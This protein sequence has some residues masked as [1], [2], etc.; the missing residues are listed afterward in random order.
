MAEAP[1]VFLV[2][3]DHAVRDSLRWLVETINLDVETY[4]SAKSF[5]DACDPD[6]PGCLVLDVRMPGMSGLELQ[7]TLIGRGITLPIIVITGYGDVPSAVRAMRQGAVDFLEKPFDDQ[8]LLELIQHCVQRDA[9]NRQAEATRR[10][11]RKNLAKL[12]PREREVLDL[13]VSGNSNKE[14]ARCLGV[15]PKTIE[16]HRARVMEKMDVTSLAKLAQMIATFD[17]HQENP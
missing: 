2:D 14:T 1:T 13:V 9:R 15:S 16:V 6:R 10:E 7:E 11:V 3:D 17:D 5:L 4:A 8:A 12:T